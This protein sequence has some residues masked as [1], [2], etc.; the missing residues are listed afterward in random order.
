MCEAPPRHQAGYTAVQWVL[1][2]CQVTVKRPF[3]HLSS[4]INHHRS[5]SMAHLEDVCRL[6]ELPQFIVKWL[7][8]VIASSPHS[9]NAGLASIAHFLPLLLYPPPTSKF[10]EITSLPWVP[11][12]LLDFWHFQ[13]SLHYFSIVL[14]RRN[15]TCLI[16][17]LSSNVY[18]LSGWVQFWGPRSEVLALLHAFLEVVGPGHFQKTR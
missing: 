13:V 14:V 12:S 18:L 16:C 10:F 3:A 8:W 7:L 6:P 2:S 15:Q 11:L 4:V 17:G 1:S 5:S 9:C